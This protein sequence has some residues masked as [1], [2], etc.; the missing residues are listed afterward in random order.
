LLYVA[1]GIGAALENIVPPVPADTFVLFG[2]FLAAAGRADPGIVFLATW[3]P[4]VAT[5]IL[6][7]GVARRYGPSVFESGVGRWLLQPHQLRQIGRF[8]VRWGAPAIFISRFL[9][10]FR[11]MVPIFAGISRV[12]LRRILLPLAGASAVWYGAL[13]LVGTAAGRNWEAILAAFGRVNGVLLAIAVGFF[14]LFLFWWY[15]SRRRRG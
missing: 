12:P 9:P 5:S 3:L 8:Y 1:I 14:A 7:Y 13:V 2:A 10:A 11:A 4:N 6:V 15:R